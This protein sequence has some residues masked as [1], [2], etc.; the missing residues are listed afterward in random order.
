[1]LSF[2]LHVGMNVHCS[3]IAELVLLQ[4]TC[5]RNH[6]FSLIFV[7][8]DIVGEKSSYSN[9]KMSGTGIKIP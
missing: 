8:L 9:E 4:L 3:H 5:Y 1:M 7:M 2:V 6:T